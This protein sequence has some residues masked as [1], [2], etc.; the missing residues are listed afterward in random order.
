MI[1]V[2]IPTRQRIKGLDRALRSIWDTSSSEE[3]VEIV[4][5]CDEDDQETINYLK[6]IDRGKHNNLQVLVGPRMDGYKSLPLFVNDMAVAAKGYLLFTCNDDVIFKTQ[7]WDRIVE[8]VA[9]R[10][11]DG[12]FDIGVNTILNAEIFPFYILSKRWLEIAGCIQDPRLIWQS[13][14]IQDVANAFGRTYYIEEVVVEH[15]WAGFKED[16]ITRPDTE[17]WAREIV[18]KDPTAHL[19]VAESTTDEWRDDY[20]QVYDK[21]IAETIEKLKPHLDPSTKPTRD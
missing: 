9:S 15:D 19:H 6:G 18:L 16:D 8:D 21:A 10:Y 5:R 14:Y 7:N 13:K 3:A 2:L 12:I 11:P 17:K 1:S 20:K 4:L